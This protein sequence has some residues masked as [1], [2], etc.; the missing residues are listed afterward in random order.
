[1][2]LLGTKAFLFLGNGLH[3]VCMA[4]PEFQGADSDSCG[5]G[6]GGHAETREEEPRNNSPVLGQDPGSPSR[7]KLKD[8]GILYP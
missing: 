1:M 5:S 4:F 8:V 6:K 3:S 2:G 7:D